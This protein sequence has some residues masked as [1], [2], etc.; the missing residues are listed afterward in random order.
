MSDSLSRDT[1]IKSIGHAIYILLIF[2]YALISLAYFGASLIVSGV[3]ILGY[4]WWGIVWALLFFYLA[5]ILFIHTLGPVGNWL[6]E[7]VDGYL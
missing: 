3:I 5:V 2:A 1:E 7:K 4:G 6:S